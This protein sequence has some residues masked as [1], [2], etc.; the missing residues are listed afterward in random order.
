MENK[1]NISAATLKG[2]CSVGACWQMLYD[3]ASQLAEMHG[4]DIAHGHV[5]LRHITVQGRHFILEE[6]KSPATACPEQDIW[7]LAAAAFELMMGSPVFNGAGECAQQD[8]TPIPSLPQPEAEELNKL[9]IKCLNHQKE[10]RPNAKEIM[11]IAS[12]NLKAFSKKERVPRMQALVKST[13]SQDKTDRQWPE[14]M[15][16]SL[17]RNIIVLLLLMMTIPAFSQVSLDKQA[18]TVTQKLLDAVLLL[19]NGDVNSWNTAQDELEKR[20][21]QFTLMNE[22]QDRS[23]DCP[24]VSSQVKTFGVNRIVMGLK[25]GQRVQMSGPELLDGADVRFNYSL[26]EKAIKKGCT[27]TYSLSGRNG[28]QVFLIVPHSSRQ[29][30]TTELI[31][32]DGSQITPS[33]KDANGVTYYLIDTDDGPKA[34]ENLYLKITNKDSDNNASFVVINHNYRDKK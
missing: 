2:F 29:V 24:L 28:K 12:D 33:G 32:E 8:S 34:G 6:E 30:Y 31:R 17:G 16:A 11:D 7:N 15:L 21:S 9:I 4:R 25:K 23:N 26:F 20:L 5:D 1:D 3:L 22:L 27:A 10:K 13:E 18:E 14:K 19:R